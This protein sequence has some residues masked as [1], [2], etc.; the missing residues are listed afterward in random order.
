MR[1]GTSDRF[2]DRRTG[3]FYDVWTA[4]DAVLKTLGVGIGKG[5]TWFSVLGDRQHEPS[6]VV[7][8]C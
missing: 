1:R 4:K 3:A 8:A 2:A 6:I 5:M 7:R